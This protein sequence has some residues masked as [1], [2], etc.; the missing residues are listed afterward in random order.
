MYGQRLAC[1]YIVTGSTTIQRDVETQ[2]GIVRVLL[3]HEGKK[4]FSRERF[5]LH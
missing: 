2:P 5:C 4:R 1:C 3:W